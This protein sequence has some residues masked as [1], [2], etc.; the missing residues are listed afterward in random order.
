MRNADADAE[1]G[2]S[3]EHETRRKEDE[4]DV[5]RFQSY[6]SPIGGSIMVCLRPGFTCD[7]FPGYICAL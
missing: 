2:K 6:E 4:E 7:V 5:R 1:Q 3:E